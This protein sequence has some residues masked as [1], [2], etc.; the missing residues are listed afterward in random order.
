MVMT[1]ANIQSDRQRS[2][3]LKYIPVGSEA[4][5]AYNM[6]DAA[7]YLGISGTALQNTLKKQKERGHSIKRYHLGIGRDWYILLRD[8]DALL[9]AKEE[10]KS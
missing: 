5:P 6:T 3:R 8:L 1:M 10:D 4:M 9:K 2:L 7:I